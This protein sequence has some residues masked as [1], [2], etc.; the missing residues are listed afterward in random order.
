MFRGVAIEDSEGNYL[1]ILV[2]DGVVFFNNI[3]SDM[4]LDIKDE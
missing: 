4:V 1:I 3:K 2:D